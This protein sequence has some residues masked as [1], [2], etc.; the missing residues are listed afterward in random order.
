MTKADHPRYLDLIREKTKPLAPLAAARLPRRFE[1]RLFAAPGAMPDP[2]G[3]GVRAVLFDI[4]GTLFCSAAGNNGAEK[5]ARTGTPDQPEPAGDTAELDRL[6]RDHT[7]CASG[8]ELRAGFRKAVRERHEKAKTAYPEVRVEEI[9]DKFP[10]R[11]ISGEELALRYELAVNPAYPMPGAAELFAVLGKSG[12]ALGIIS[13]AQFYTPLLFEAFFGGPP[14]ALGFSPDLLFYSYREGCSKP[15][16]ALFEKARRALGQRGLENPVYLGNDMLN[17]I[18]GAASAGFRTVLFA[19]D[20]RSL[21]LR[22]EDPRTAALLPD[23]AVFCLAGF[24][25]L[26]RAWAAPAEK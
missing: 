15:S 9:W 26:L 16:P 3:R 19:G 8:E 23:A 12:L 13:N 4:Y 1:E 22:E 21:R 18:Y 24:G 17:D 2:P 10:G 11:K 5:S 14:E 20:G 25:I 6:A 7:S